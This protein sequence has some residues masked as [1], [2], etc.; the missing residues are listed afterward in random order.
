MAGVRQNVT[1]FLSAGGGQLPCINARVSKTSKRKGDH[2]DCK[3][4]LDVA[5]A[6]SLINGGDASVI[7][8]D[9]TKTVSLISGKIDNISVEWIDREICVT[10]RD[11]SAV[12]T[13]KRLNKQFK[14]K[15]TSAIVEEIAK[16]A[17]LTAQ[18]SSTDDDSGKKYDVDT[19]HLA[20][21]RTAS[22]TLSLLAE[23]EGHRWYVTGNAL[24]FEPKD[25]GNSG[26]SFQVTYIPP[27]QGYETSNATYIRCSRNLTAAR[28]TDVKVASWHHKDKKLYKATASGGSGS[29]DKLTYELHFPGMTQAQVE[30]IAKSHLSDHRRHELSVE[31]DMPGDLSVASNGVLQLQGT[32][33]MF[34][35]S[36]DI[37]SIEFHYAAGEQGHFSM[38]IS[39]KTPGSDKGGA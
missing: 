27:S 38:S 19:V 34:D 3:L 16:D 13:E 21:N 26:G 9:G 29:G 33:S 7:F 23:R 5:G 11:K 4:P 28:P 6:K 30:K 35:T 2:F 10:G 31:V 37:D 18:I 24:H 14:N 17:G 12:L 32:G 39:G 22:E 1:A 8:S 15:K 25:A 20:L 36:Y